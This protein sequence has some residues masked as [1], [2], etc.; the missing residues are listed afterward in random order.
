MIRFYH[1]SLLFSACIFLHLPLALGQNESER[2]VSRQLDSLRI[3]F[4]S[5]QAKLNEKKVETSDSSLIL[6]LSKIVQLEQQNYDASA[7][8]ESYEKLLRRDLGLQLNL[9]G[10]QNF[11]IS[12][13]DLEE[14][15]LYQRRFQTGLEWNLLKGGLLD[16]RSALKS[17]PNQEMYEQKLNYYQHH[18]RN[19]AAKM[20]ECIYWFNQHKIALLTQR[21][22]ILSKQYQALEKLYFAKKITREH[23]LRNQTRMAEITGMQGIYQSY[24]EYFP[25]L[26]DT[27]L[28]TREAPLFDLN[29]EKL[30]SVVDEGQQLDSLSVL[31]RK[32][33]EQ[34]KW[35]SEIRLKAFFK[36][37][38][39]DL[40]TTNPS[41]RAFYNA[42]ITAGIPL[43]FSQKQARE[44]ELQKVGKQLDQLQLAQ[45]NK[46]IEVLNDAY[47]FRYQLKQYIVFHQKRILAWESVRQERVKSKLQDADFNP[48]R[49]LELLDDLLQLEIELLD[50]KQN[51]Y[52]KLLKIQEKTPGV[53]MQELIIPLQLPNYFNFEDDTYRTCYVWSKTFEQHDVDFLSEYILYN[54]FDEIQL[55]I[56]REDK[57]IQNKLKLIEQLDAKGIKVQLMLG[58]NELLGDPNYSKIVAEMLKP[59]LDK[60][61]S[62]LHLDIEPH[63]RDDW[64]SKREELQAQY[65]VLLKETKT[66][67][68]TYNLKLSIDLPLSLDTMYAKELIEQVQAVRFM[69]YENIKEDYLLRKLSPYKTFGDKLSVSLRTEDFKSRQEMEKFAKEFLQKSGIK[70]INFHDLNRLIAL[71]KQALVPD[72]EH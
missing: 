36:Y 71:D 19:S 69:C 24:N 1:I 30:L 46:R 9:D 48:I 45:Q 14:N 15:I 42:G 31:L 3:I 68:S 56:A 53:S 54:Q 55:A 49:G 26:T 41:A 12:Q 29:Y 67:C 21:W 72:E 10:I 25:G 40:L 17:L 35:Y 37:N 63:T 66:V 39:Y 59:Y 51:L 28:M 5:E 11:N 8:Y 20:N 50:L 27:T 58:Q 44:F 23:L 18:K 64:K 7:Y 34:Q 13:Q 70:A 16:S 47:E 43:P 65:K 61:I 4:H 22:D 62:G 32:E 60:G 38:Y 6:G 57:Q 33:A 2:E 52:I